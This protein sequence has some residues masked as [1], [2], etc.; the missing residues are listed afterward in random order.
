MSDNFPC[1]KYLNLPA[2]PDHVIKDELD[3]FP[4]AKDIA[5]SASI[6]YGHTDNPVY[7]KTDI[8]STSLKEWLNHNISNQ[9]HYAFQ[10]IPGKDGALP[11][12]KDV[13]TNQK[14][15]YILDT[16]GENVLTNFYDDEKNLLQSIKIE[17]KRWHIIDVTKFHEVI[18]IDEDEVRLSI[19]GKIFF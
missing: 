18:G 13:K 19:T 16:A 2:I 11:L 9:M 1:C 4:D 14:L 6:K 3:Y 8:T 15:C 12:H 7:A 17:P 5:K 10:I